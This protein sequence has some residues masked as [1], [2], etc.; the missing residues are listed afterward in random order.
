QR[1]LV[2]EVEGGTAAG[3]RDL[4]VVEREALDRQHAV[5]AKFS[6]GTGVQRVRTEVEKDRLRVRLALRRAHVDG[7]LPIRTDLARSPTH[8][9]AQLVSREAAALVVQRDSGEREI[10]RPGAA[11]QRSCEFRSAVA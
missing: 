8:A 1:L 7:E 4:R 3:L 11:A 10:E 6:S 2:R 9:R 5:A